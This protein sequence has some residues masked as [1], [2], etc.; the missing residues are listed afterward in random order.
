MP[1]TIP[2]T[3]KSPTTANENREALHAVLKEYGVDPYR[4]P[5]E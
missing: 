4:E 5:V 3:T 1:R 2:P